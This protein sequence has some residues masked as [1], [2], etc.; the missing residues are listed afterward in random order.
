MQNVVVWFLA[1]SEP[2]TSW[3]LKTG[4]RAQFPAFSNLLG[5]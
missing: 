5:E 2:Q 1:P 4:D 3:A